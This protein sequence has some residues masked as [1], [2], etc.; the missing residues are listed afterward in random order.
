MTRLSVKSYVDPWPI[1]SNATT[2]FPMF[3][4]KEAALY[5]IMA[6]HWTGDKP[7][8]INAGLVHWRDAL[9]INQVKPSDV[10]PT[11]DLR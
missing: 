2:N 1:D 11:S 3:P 9:L 8:L 5:Q 10:S 7:F 6:W 4:I